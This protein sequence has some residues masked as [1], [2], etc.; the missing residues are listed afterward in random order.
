[1]SD[2]IFL[3]EKSFCIA[4]VAAM[5]IEAAACMVVKILWVAEL[6][7]CLRRTIKGNTNT[8]NTKKKKN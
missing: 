5:K 3:L 1:M 8:T 2:N 7:V 4:L 6:S